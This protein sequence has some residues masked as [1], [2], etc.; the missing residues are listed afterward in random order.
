M[1][2][3]PS[4]FNANERGRKLSD[5]GDDVGAEA[6]YREAITL[7]PNFESGWFNLGL[8]YKRRHDWAETLRCNLRA[9][10]LNPRREQ[11]AWWN[12]GIAATALRDWSIARKAWT[13]YGIDIPPGEGPIE[14]NFGHTPVRIGIPE[15]LEVVWCRRIDPA[16]AEILNIPTPESGHRYGD[17]VLHDGEPKGQ[18]ESNGQ[19]FS[20]FDELERWQPSDVPTVVVS[21]T[22]RSDADALAATSMA[23][24]ADLICE[25]WTASIQW[26]CKACSVGR[27]HS[28]HDHEGDPKWHAQHLFG[29]AS[30]PSAV[31]RFLES[32]TAAGP[33]RA[34]GTLEVIEASKPGTGC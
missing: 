5:Q 22:C 14:A 28:H 32:W 9:A 17:I 19:L 23:Q 24:E 27:S 10:E 7:D 34:F 16:R 29:F 6:A 15:P 4:A 25:D 18:R 26:L 12:L 33:G 21:L 3:F 31:S 8:V 11:P 2:G 30:D 20:V 13:G 1:L